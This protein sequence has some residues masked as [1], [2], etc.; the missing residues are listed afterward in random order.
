M[1]IRD[2]VLLRERDQAAVDLDRGDLLRQVAQQRGLV[3]GA[4]ADF[5]HTVGLAQLQFLG[6]A[7]FDL[8]GEHGLAG[9]DRVD[10]Q[11]QFQVGK[12]QGA[13]GRRNRCV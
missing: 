10:F 12:R 7:G 9:V 11:R 8:G 1:C 3:A 2:R 13:Q 4:G 6:Q 5:Q